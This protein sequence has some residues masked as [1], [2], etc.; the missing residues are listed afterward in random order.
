MKLSSLTFLAALLMLGCGDDDRPIDR[1]SGAGPFD[2]NTLD[3]SRPDVLGFDAPDP[4]NESCDKMDILF[5]VDDSGSM[6]EEQANLASNFPR[7]VQVLDDFRNSAGREIDY[8]LGVTTTGADHVTIIDFSGFG[9]PPMTIE[10]EGPAGEL[11]QGCGMTRKWIE[12]SDPDVS[13]TFSCVAEVGTGGS[14]TEMP[15]GMLE[16]ALTERMAD[17]SNVGFLRDDALLA[18]VILTDEDDCSKDERETRL[19]LDPFAPGGPGGAADEC[20]GDSLIPISRVLATVDA[21]KMERGRWAAAV[22]AGPT[23]CESAFGSAASADRLQ[24]FVSQVGDNATFSSICEGDLSSA[25]MD[26]LNTFEV[27]C[28][29]F[30]P[31]I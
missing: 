7:F 21:A 2:A 30:P 26:A 31:L 22:I 28:Q 19:T 18:V 4:G 1:D 24:D 27:A 11:Q 14:S 29:S 9:I 3:V 5:I 10:E 13:S 20:S 6:G 25:L 17:G 8:R 16:L 23:D 12:R 15:L